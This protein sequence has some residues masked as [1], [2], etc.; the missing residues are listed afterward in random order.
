MRDSS[1]A[2]WSRG[3]W[4][5][6]PPSCS[7]TGHLDLLAETALAAIRSGEMRR[8]PSL[9]RAALADLDAYAEPVRA[10]PRPPSPGMPV[11]PCLGFAR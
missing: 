9:T 7:A 8:A 3:T 1:T 6:P 10:A 11:E 4:C 2:S 5:R